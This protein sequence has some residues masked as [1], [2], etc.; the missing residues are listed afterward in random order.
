L[1]DLKKN[2]S[3]KTAHEMVINKRLVPDF[4]NPFGWLFGQNWPK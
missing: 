4:M 2:E 3:L 1:R